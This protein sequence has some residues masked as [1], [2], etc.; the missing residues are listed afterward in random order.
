MYKSEIRQSTINA[1]LEK[2]ANHNYGKYLPKLVLK[3]IRG[4]N[5][6]PVSFDFPVTAII[7]PNGGGKTTILGAAGCAYRTVPPKR[8]FSKSGIFDQTMAEWAIEYELVDREQ[9]KDIIRR[10]ASFRNLR[11]NREALDREV[12]IFGV[13]RTVPANERSEL[14]RCASSTFKVPDSSI[15]E[16]EEPVCKAV[17]GILG[18]DITGFKRLAIDPTGRILLTGKTA[19]GHGYSEFHFGAG[20]SSVI[21]MVSQLSSRRN[22]RLCS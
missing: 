6:E 11:W 22:K 4:F 10:T 7:G 15:A 8:F 18:K 16:I 3:H 5:N 2:A 17:S 19:N 1:L 21:R 12:L 14:L 13:S 9:N 20:E